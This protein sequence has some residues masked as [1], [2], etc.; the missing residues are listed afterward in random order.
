MRSTA[1]VLLTTLVACGPTTPP[2][3][4]PEATIA[5]MAEI[6]PGTPLHD[7]LEMLDQHLVNAM[8]GQLEGTAGDEFLRAEAI[9]DR[10]L[11]AR[12]P[13]EWIPSE[14]YSL[15]SKLR[16]IQSSA[17]RVLAQLRTAA[18]RPQMLQDLRSLRTDV[19]LLR[20]TVAAGGGPAPV[21]IDRLMSG[22]TS[23]FAERSISPTGSPDTQSPSAPAPLG[24]PVGQ[25][26]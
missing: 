22:D 1:L 6:R 3:D 19:A 11:E 25:G 20:R 17:D 2:D 13:F 24:T 4:V 21:P 18:P 9:T 14:N 10:L 12:M 16:Q 8:A 23:I 5:V 7:M 15:E 26:E